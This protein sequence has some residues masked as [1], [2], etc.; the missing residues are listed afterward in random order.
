MT[1]IVEEIYDA[2]LA[3]NVPVDKAKAAARVMVVK[4]DV[5]MKT[6][7]ESYVKEQDLKEVLVAINTTLKE[8]QESQVGIREEIAEVR[9]E[10]KE[11]SNREAFWD[12]VKVGV[13]VAILVL[14][15]KA[16]S[17]EE[18]MAVFS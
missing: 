8:L 16:V 2:L 7:L 6:D 13:L 1:A 17:W 9:G 12:K 5:V 15:L 18:L 14:F 4:E 3:A 11:R 10:L